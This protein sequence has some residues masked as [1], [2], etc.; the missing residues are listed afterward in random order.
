MEIRSYIKDFEKLGFGMFVHFGLYSLL[1]KGEWALHGKSV[2]ER[3]QYNQLINEFDIKEGY[4]KDIVKTAKDAGCKYIIL[5]TRH[6]DGFSLYDT[7]G[8][9]DFDVMHSPTGRDILAEFVS[10]CNQEGIVPFFY[11]TG[12]DWNRK[13]FNDDFPAYLEYLYKSIEFLCTN[14]GRIGG[15]WFDG[16][17]DRDDWNFDRLIEIIRTNQPN[18]MIVFN[19]GL[20]HNENYAKEVDC[21]TFERSNPRNESNS[22]DRYR[23]REMC[24]VINDHW[25]YSG[26]DFNCK[27]IKVLLENLT[28]CRR[29][30]SNFVLN[31]GPTKDGIALAEKA[32]FELFGKWMKIYGDI[33]YNGVPVPEISVNNDK[34]FV[35]EM[36]GEYYLFVHD[37][38]TSGDINVALENRKEKQVVVKGLNK[39]IKSVVFFDNQTELSF[40]EN[41]GDYTIYCTNFEYSRNMLIRVA[42]IIVAD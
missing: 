24:Q 29:F 4:F 37:L 19:R 14:Y 8:L 5:T 6:H 11:H 16:F 25:G 32:V 38:S 7:K 17:W 21:L 15:L 41:N 3:E 31:V 9:S 30:Q 20:L 36:N 40:T 28:L 33:I 27:P 2:I 10:E 1:G 34:D 42:K 18:A 35:L 22:D 26:D 39:I 13:E 12:I 23:A